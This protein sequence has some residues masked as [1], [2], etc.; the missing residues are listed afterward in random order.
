MRALVR[1][2][3]TA[4]LLCLA[5]PGCVSSLGSPTSSSRSL[6]D[7]FV[8]HPAPYPQ[9][10][11]NP[12][13]LRFE[14]AWF[15]A[16]DGTR[17]HGWYCP[18]P[19]ARAVVLY[20]HGNAGN[21]TSRYWP[22]KLLVEKLNVSVLCF[23]YRGYGKSE[24][25]PTEDGILG[26]ARAARRWLAERS[27]VAEADIVLLGNS[28]GGAVA[29]HLAARDGARG[30]VLENTFTS[31]PDVAASKVGSIPVQLSMKTRLDSL[32]KIGRYRGPLLQTHGDADRVVPF[33]LGRKLFAAANPPKRFVAVPGGGHNGPP[34]REYVQ[35]LA[36]FL[37][38]LPASP[39]EVAE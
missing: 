18:A 6:L 24:G 8:F 17:L 22:L 11:W 37:H 36:E 20:C 27:G 7:S 13:D 1:R 31:V 14:D 12:N 16:A 25:T 4:C 15:Q 39:V 38:S 21:V 26:D 33:E 2:L 32:A 19:D 29:V 30:L 10:D 28:L 3:G 23:D 35:A 9:G 34:S 5:V